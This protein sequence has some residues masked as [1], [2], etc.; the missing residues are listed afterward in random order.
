MALMGVK[1][2]MTLACCIASDPNCLS[3]Q[4]YFFALLF[5]VLRSATW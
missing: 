1:S 4:F 2:G 5:M 3:V